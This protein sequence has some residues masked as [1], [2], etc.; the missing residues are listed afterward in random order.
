M[1]QFSVSASLSDMLDGELRL[2]ATFYT[3]SAYLARKIVDDY[4]SVSSIAAFS[5]G[6]FNPPPIKRVYTDNA[7][8]GTPYM[9][10]KEMFDFYWAP[11]KYIISE[12]MP[13][14][15]DWFLKKGWVVLTQSGS[16]GKPYFAASSDEKLVL[17]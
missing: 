2:D 14:I 13:K 16:V 8:I 3:S 9:L 7:E 11:K 10:P 17:S 15:E 4:G 1:K 5:K 6:T 12:K